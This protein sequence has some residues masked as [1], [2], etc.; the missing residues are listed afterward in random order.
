M[1]YCNEF[2]PLIFFEAQSS[3]VGLLF[4]I[5]YLFV[6]LS[7]CVYVRLS[8]CVGAYEAPQSV[9]Q[10]LHRGETCTSGQVYH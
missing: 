1:K 4:N 10:T 9:V 3:Q 7:V 8:A 6:S 5:I 2:C